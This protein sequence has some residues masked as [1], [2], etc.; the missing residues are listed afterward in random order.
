MGECG[1]TGARVSDVTAAAGVAK[2]T[3]YVHFPSW[4]DLVVAVRDHVGD[5]FRREVMHRAANIEGAAWQAFIENEAVLFIDALIAMGPLHEAIFHGPAAFKP[6]KARSSIVALI[7]SLLKRGASDG[8][9]A[10]DN[11]RAAALLLF[12]AW[13]ATADAIAAKAGRTRHLEALRQ[14][15][16]RWLSAP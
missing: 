7:E 1:D 16:R 2:G 12:S 15:M 3:F 10:V 9:F 6:T 14:L 4:D 13:H 5:G 11:T 8:A